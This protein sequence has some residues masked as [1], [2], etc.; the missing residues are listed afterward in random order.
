MRFP[1]QAAIA[2]SIWCSTDSLAFLIAR[3]LRPTLRV[4]V[5]L[6]AAI[7]IFMI[8]FSRLYLGAHWLSD[9]L[10]GLAFGCAWLALLGL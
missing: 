3:E 5:A 9:V 8:A 7:L 2:Q 10:G 4:L 6:V 1:F